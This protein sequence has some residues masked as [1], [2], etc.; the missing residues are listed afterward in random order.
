MIR[1]RKIALAS[2]FSPRFLPLL[3][4]AWSFVQKLECEFSLIHAGVEN[5]EKAQQFESA[6]N[7]LSISPR[8]EIHW[9]EGEPAEAI[10]NT[11][12]DRGIDLLLAGALE[13]ESAGRHYVG[14]VAR[15]LLREAPC[16]LLLFTSPSVHP[17]PFHRIVTIT[18]FSWL[19]ESCL[20]QT[21]F[22]ARHS[23]AECIRIVRIFTIFDQALGQPEEFFHKKDARRSMLEAEERRIM[24]L[25]AAA[26]PSPVPIEAVCVE[27]TTGFAASDYVQAVDADLLVIP[28]RLPGTPQLLPDG[29]DWVFSVIPSNLFIVREEVSS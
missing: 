5:E 20:K 22:L 10:L 12:R 14:N 16:S 28:S 27:G 15:K 25:A 19:S 18:D 8:P 2:T 24:E 9:A 3:A 6:F 17:E 21:Y 7:E 26:G 4:E 13:K 11:I 1:Y 23:A 29:M